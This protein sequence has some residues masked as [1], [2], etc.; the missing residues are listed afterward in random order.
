MRAKLYRGRWYAT[1]TDEA[2][3]TKRAALRT[4]DREEAERKLIDLK[5]DMAAP[6][7]NATVGQIVQ[8]Y[9]DDCRGRVTDFARLEYAWKQAERTFAH[10]RPNQVDR[11]VCRSYIAARRLAGRKDATILKEINV[12]RQALNW[13]LGKGNTGAVFEAP[14]ASPPRDRYLTRGEYRAL[15]AGCAQ[16]HVRL[17]CILALA[18][19]ARMSAILELTWD[20]VDLAGGQ[21]KLAVVGQ[22]RKKGRATVPITPHA[23]E[24]L[25][26]AM[27]ARRTP[28]V[29]EYADARVGSIK[30]GFAAAVRRA[31]LADVTP[32][33][34]RHTAAVWMAEAGVSMEEIGQYLGHSDAR[35]T[36][37]TYARF[38]PG[39]LRKAASALSY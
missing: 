8:A 28:Y 25:R 19:A 24:A 31:D 18:T 12:V 37:R 39:H 35:V 14:P 27:E 3:R 4:A 33:V 11:A 23:A 20:R 13:R 36:Y 30:T 5:R 9:L 29:I 15:L 10:L 1:W 21:I 32:H 22:Q 2:G 16:P 38:S 6:K 17:F 7:E 34:L 26:D